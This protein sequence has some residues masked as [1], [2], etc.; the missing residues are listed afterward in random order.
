MNLI[1]SPYH[2]MALLGWLH[3]IA[4]ALLWDGVIDPAR[5]AWLWIAVKLIPLL[6][7]LPGLVRG[8]SF[9]LQLASMVVLL[10]MVEGCVRGM[11]SSPP[12]QFIGWAQFVLSWITFFGLILHVRPMKQAAKAKKLEQEKHG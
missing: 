3:L 5:G 9:S 7:L 1:K 6:A 10:Y 12:S 11:T 2:L 4:L 8:T